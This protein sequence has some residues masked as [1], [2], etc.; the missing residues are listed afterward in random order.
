MVLTIEVT[1]QERAVTGVS[2]TNRIG[3]LQD[4]KI[5][6]FEMPNCTI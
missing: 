5:G 6:Q 2:A 3:R 4:R 1:T